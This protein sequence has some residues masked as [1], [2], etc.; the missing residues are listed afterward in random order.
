[1]SFAEDGQLRVRNP[2]RAPHRIRQLQHDGRGPE[3]TAL[4][5]DNRGIRMAVTLEYSILGPVEI[6][7]DGVSVEIR[8]EIQRVLLTA[9]LASEGRLCTTSMLIEELWGDNPPRNSENALQAHISR[10]RRRLE[11]LE[12]HSARPRLVSSSSSYRLCVG[13]NELDATRFTRSLHEVR[14]QPDM[15]PA[16]A[17]HTLRSALALWRGPAVVPATGGAICRAAAA[18]YEESRRAMLELLYDNELKLGRHSEII[19]ELRELTEESGLNER[20]CEQLMVALYRAGRQSDALA[21]YRQ[22]WSR[23]KSE[24]GVEPSPML[25]RYERA[26]LTHHPILNRSAD[27]LALRA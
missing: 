25:K 12:P 5:D 7:A 26:I 15:H 9:L 4:A 13:E 24:I 6:R 10:F 8:G 2:L 16:Q 20:L 19:A 14:S 3:A 23:L 1:M 22:M 17:V 18:R 21:V 11:A 27:H